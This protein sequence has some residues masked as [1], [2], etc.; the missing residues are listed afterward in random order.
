MQTITVSR[1]AAVSCSHARRYPRPE[2]SLL[3]AQQCFAKLP[4]FRAETIGFWNGFPYEGD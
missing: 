3:F 1:N 2:A 4:G